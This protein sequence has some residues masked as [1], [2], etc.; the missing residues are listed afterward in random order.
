MNTERGQPT[1]KRR[2]EGI[3]ATGR[4]AD[5]QE[6]RVEG[7]WRMAATDR[8]GQRPSVRQRGGEPRMPRMASRLIRRTALS[9]E[10]ALRAKSG[11]PRRTHARRTESTSGDDGGLVVAGREKN[12]RI[13]L[14][15]ITGWREE[16]ESRPGRSRKNRADFAGTSREARRAMNN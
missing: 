5:R 7:P 11:E 10:L 3:P 13:S 12:P 15:G 8:A 1:R 6:G 16:R 14:S 9:V 4:K 2:G